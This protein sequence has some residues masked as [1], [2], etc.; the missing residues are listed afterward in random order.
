MVCKL[1]ALKMSKPGLLQ[2]AIREDDTKSG[3]ACFTI[4]VTL[5]YLRSYSPTSQGFLRSRS[6][7]NRSESLPVILH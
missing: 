2:I 7:E 1:Q 4:H 6:G 5:R 3:S